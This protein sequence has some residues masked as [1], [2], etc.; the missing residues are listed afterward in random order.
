MQVFIWFIKTE[1]ARKMNIQIRVDRK[2]I[3]A[4]ILC[5]LR[6]QCAQS[7]FTRT[8]FADE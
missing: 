6:K 2:D 1:K 5:V 4:L 7:T 3:L 8:P